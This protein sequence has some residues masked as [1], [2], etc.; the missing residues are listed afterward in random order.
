M[1]KP[2]EY[3]QQ[4][5]E[6]YNLVKNENNMKMIKKNDLDDIL[7]IVIKIENNKLFRGK[8]GEIMRV[9]VSRLIECIA[10]TEI[11]LEEEHIK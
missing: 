7:N 5:L 3:R 11:E 9:A 4:F 8:G 6:N 2:G 1:I 10:I